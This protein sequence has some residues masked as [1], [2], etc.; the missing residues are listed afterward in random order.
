MKKTLLQFILLGP[1]ALLI[2]ACGESDYKVLTDYQQAVSAPDSQ[3]QTCL[4]EYNGSV[5]AVGQGYGVRLPMDSWRAEQ[6]LTKATE[7]RDE[8]ALVTVPEVATTVGAMKLTAAN[9]II[10]A[11][12]ELLSVVSTWEERVPVGPPDMTPGAE[13]EYVELDLT[14][15]HQLD[16]DLTRVEELFVEADELLK[17]GALALAGAL[18][19]S[20]GE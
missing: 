13:L 7:A 18:L 12:E 5:L 15:V 10:S 11:V 3:L 20:R 14:E 1:F 16:T 19:K 17:D 2:T 9:S 8:L 6:L 4:D